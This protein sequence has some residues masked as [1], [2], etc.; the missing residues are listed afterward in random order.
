MAIIQKQGFIFYF[1]RMNFWK[2]FLVV[3]FFSICCSSPKTNLQ[4]PNIKWTDMDEP[5]LYNGCPKDSA[6][7]NWSCFT[8]IIQNKLNK[9]FTSNRISPVDIDTLFVALKVD[10]I[11][12]LSITGYSNT[13]Q[14]SIP[15]LVFSS[16]EEVVASLRRFQPAFKTNLEIPVEVHWTLPVAISK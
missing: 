10:T 1:Y 2:L 8:E 4:T 15:P 3:L 12:H 7:E 11:G 5:P 13:K 14:G 16:V 6:K 9:K